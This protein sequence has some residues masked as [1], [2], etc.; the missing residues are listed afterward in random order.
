MMTTVEFFFLIFG[1]LALLGGIEAVRSHRATLSNTAGEIEVEGRQAFGHGLIALAS[2]SI[3]LIGLAVGSKP[4]AMVGFM[5]IILGSTA[6]ALIT[7]THE[8][9][10]GYRA[11]K[12]AK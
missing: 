1:V 2:G 7:I 9:V 11:K 12:K 5:G 3:T 8:A 10:Q 6:L 4:L